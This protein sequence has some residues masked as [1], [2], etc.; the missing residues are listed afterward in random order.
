MLEN[1]YGLENGKTTPDMKFTLQIVACLGSCFM[2][3]CM[4]INNDYYGN[5]D[6]EKAKKIIN[7][8]K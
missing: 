3:P 7:S 5:L 8:L 4:M 6:V 2:A 1:E